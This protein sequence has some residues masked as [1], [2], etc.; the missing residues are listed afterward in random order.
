MSSSAQS[1]PIIFGS[2]D[3]FQ[4]PNILKGWAHTA[5]DGGP[6]SLQ[7]QVFEGDRLIGETTTDIFRGDI[8]RRC[9]FEVHLSSAPEIPKLISGDVRVCAINANDQ[10]I[11]LPIWQELV[12]VMSERPNEPS[13]AAPRPDDAAAGPLAADADAAVPPSSEGSNGRRDGS[14]FRARPAEEP[15]RTARGVGT[16]GWIA[17]TVALLVAAVAASPWWAPR[18]APLLP[19]SPQSGTASGD[20]GGIEERLAALERRGEAPASAGP[21]QPPPETASLQ[22]A[23]DKVSRVLAGL[24]QRLAGAEQAQLRQS[25]GQ[26]ASGGTEDLAPLRADIERQGSEIAKFA[27]RV[28]AIEKHLSKRRRSTAPLAHLE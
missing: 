7:I 21:A 20:G 12:R 22:R 10:S 28:A 18:L 11:T 23:L 15:P 1:Q 8:E 4:P 14:P 24:E 16:P 9:G 19:W 27:D 13:G 6:P 2:V 17:L 5:K 26:N 3:G 25:A